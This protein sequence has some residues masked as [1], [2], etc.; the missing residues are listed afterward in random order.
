[1]LGG[2]VLAGTRRC[3]QKCWNASHRNRQTSERLK[4]GW[5]HAGCGEWTAFAIWTAAEVD[6][7]PVSAYVTMRE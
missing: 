1:M 5:R 4:R 3:K 7:T 6:P 2:L